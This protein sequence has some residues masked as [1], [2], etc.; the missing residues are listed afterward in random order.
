MQW[1][2]MLQWSRLAVARMVNTDSDLHSM[3]KG[4]TCCCA[5]PLIVRPAPDSQVATSWSLTC[6]DLP[7]F[8]TA[9]NHFWRKSSSCSFCC[10]GTWGTAACKAWH[11][12]SIVTGETYACGRMCWCHLHTCITSPCNLCSA[13]EIKALE[14]SDRRYSKSKRYSSLPG[15]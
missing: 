3:W 5:G 4:L 12:P 11:Q 2:Y 6:P 13:S 8:C 15:C 1:S 7:L 14:T 10:S 9:V